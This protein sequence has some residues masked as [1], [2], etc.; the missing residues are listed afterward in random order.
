MHGEPGSGLRAQCRFA[1]VAGR[2]LDVDAAG[3]PFGVL[4]LDLRVRVEHLVPLVEGK[5]EFGGDAASLGIGGLFAVLE[6]DGLAPARDGTLEFGV[7]PHAHDGGALFGE[8]LP[9]LPSGAVDGGV[10]PGLGGPHA[11]RPDPLRGIHPAPGSPFAGLDDS[12]AG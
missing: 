10:V 5:P 8:A 6:P 11:V 1:V 9:F 7:E 3:P 2:D 4:V 12:L